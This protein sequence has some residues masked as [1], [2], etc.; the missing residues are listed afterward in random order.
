MHSLY[1]RDVE[2]SKINI[3]VSTF[4]T[5]DLYGVDN[6]VANIVLNK[7][8]LTLLRSATEKTILIYGIG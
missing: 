6:I 7:T 5:R 4:Y 8:S 3:G 2:N 1:K